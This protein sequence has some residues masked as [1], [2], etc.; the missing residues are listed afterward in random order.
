M[1]DQDTAHPI[2]LDGNF[3]EEWGDCLYLESILHHGKRGTHTV[4]IRVLPEY[5][6]ESI[7]Y[8]P[9]Y[10]LSLISA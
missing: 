3:D 9:F 4:Q 2:L 7:S 1:L 10:L 5:G 6:E 8:V